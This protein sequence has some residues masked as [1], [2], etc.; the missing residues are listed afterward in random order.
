VHFPS[1]EWAEALRTALNQNPAFQ[2]AANAWEADLLF[3]VRTPGADAPAPG[4]RLD[5]AQGRCR[6][7]TF[8]EDARPIAAEFVFEG[9]P[10]NW[11][12][13]LRRELEPVRPFIDGTFTVRGNLAKA[14][15]FSRAAKVLV[16]TAS[17]ISLDA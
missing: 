5:L 2:E 17:G 8:H 11:R 6:S 15:R 10:E 9:T 1:A 4:I 7:A 13:L 12:K 3:L 16:E 14:L